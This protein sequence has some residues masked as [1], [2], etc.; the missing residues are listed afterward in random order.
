MFDLERAINGEAICMR[1]G[2]EILELAYL[3]SAKSTHKLYGVSE[4]S[5]MVLSWTEDGIYGMGPEQQA[6]MT[7]M[8]LIMRCDFVE[9]DPS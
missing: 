1:N 4:G 8:D 9:P 5:G 3:P 7:G 2:I 6:S